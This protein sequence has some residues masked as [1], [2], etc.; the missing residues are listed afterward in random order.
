MG[1]RRYRHGGRVVEAMRFVGNGPEIAGWCGALDAHAVGRGLSG[2][3]Q[4]NGTEV[5]VG[6]WVIREGVV[7]TIVAQDV[8][9]KRF[10]EVRNAHVE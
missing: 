1:P 6:D 2:S 9:S 3:L 7:V 10:Q 5:A 4:I 8:F